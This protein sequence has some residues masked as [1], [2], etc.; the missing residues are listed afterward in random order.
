MAHFHSV[1]SSVPLH[2]RLSEF[3]DDEVEVVDHRKR[4]RAVCLARTS[5]FAVESLPWNENMEDGGEDSQ[6][7]SVLFNVVGLGADKVRM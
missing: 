1:P 4:H 5:S 3:S 7:V 6:G 2:A